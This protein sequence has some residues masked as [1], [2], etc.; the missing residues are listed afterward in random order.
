MVKG[1]GTKDATLGSHLKLQWYD[2]YLCFSITTSSIFSKMTRCKVLH[3]ANA[4]E[5]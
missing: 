1:Y 2:R 4:L 3:A 5:K